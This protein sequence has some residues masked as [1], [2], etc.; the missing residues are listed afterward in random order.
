MPLKS[1]EFV[2][3]QDKQDLSALEGINQSLI[4]NTMDY[5]TR[6]YH[7]EQTGKKKARFKEILRSPYE[8]AMLAEA[9]GIFGSLVIASE[10]IKTLGKHY[11]DISQ[12]IT[13]MLNLAKFE[14]Y[15]KG[16]VI[17]YTG[18]QSQEIYLDELQIN[19]FTIMLKRCKKFFTGD[20]SIKYT[21]FNFSG[22]YSDLVTVGE[23]DYIAG[24]TLWDM[25]C[26]KNK[27]N[28]K[29][30][31]QVFMYYLMGKHSGQEKFRD[32]I[33]IG[34]YNPF[35]NCA[36]KLGARNIS[37]FLENEIKYKVIGYKP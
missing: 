24:N 17:V 18:G 6:L 16:A 22:G 28:S 26:S 11:D 19:A 25:K 4:G 34:L 9:H 20:N 23:G 10:C 3:F 32:I 13:A 29:H 27:P 33:N 5:L 35:K 7:W 8:G 12:R 36:W 15:S 21:G 30:T 31:L 1:F 14:P 37:P 2:Q